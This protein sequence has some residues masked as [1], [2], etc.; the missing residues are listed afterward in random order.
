M[1]S[2]REPESG[3]P[4]TQLIENRFWDGRDSQGCPNP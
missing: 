3:N 2:G 4:V 1:G